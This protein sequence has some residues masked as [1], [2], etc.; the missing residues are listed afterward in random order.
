MCVCVICQDDSGLCSQS[1]SGL[2]VCMQRVC[3][4]AG[5][6]ATHV[7]R[8]L[9]GADFLWPHHA[10]RPGRELACHPCGHQTPADEDRHQFLHR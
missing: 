6:R 5:P 7:G 10:G 4:F 9:A 3:S 2:R 8:R 1:R